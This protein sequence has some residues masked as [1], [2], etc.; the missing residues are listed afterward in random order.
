MSI[1][2]TD[3]LYQHQLIVSRVFDEGEEERELENSDVIDTEMTFLIDE[4]MKFKH[5][6]IKEDNDVYQV[7]SWIGQDSKGNARNYEFRVLKEDATDNYAKTFLDAIVGCVFERKC[8]ASRDQATIDDIEMLTKQLAQVEIKSEPPT[9]SIKAKLSP[10][11]PNCVET[12]K[13]KAGLNLYDTDKSIHVFKSNVDV[14]LMKESGPH[15]V[16]WLTAEDVDKGNSGPILCLKL[17]LD[18]NPRFTNTLKSFMFIE[19][20]DGRF[21]SWMLKFNDVKSDVEF[22]TVFAKCFYEVANQRPYAKVKEDERV[23]IDRSYNLDYDSDEIVLSEEEEEAKQEEPKRTPSQ[24]I[25]NSIKENLSDSNNHNKN[26]SIGYKHDRSFISRGSNI[27]VFKHGN[28][29]EL[30]YCATITDIKDSKGKLTSPS[31][32]MLHNQDSSLLLMLPNDKSTLYDLDL[33]SGTIKQKI[34]VHDKIKCDDIFS[35][36]KYAQ[37]TS[38]QTLY[39]LNPNSMYRI[40]PRIGGKS[41]I[42]PTELKRYATKVQ[43]ICAATTPTGEIAVA[44][45]NGEILL[46]NQI[47]KNA[48][49]ALPPNGDK[50]YGLDITNDGQYIIATCKTYLL[51]VDCRIY[52]DV[53]KRTGFQKSFPKDEKPALKRLQLKPEHVAQISQ[54][55]NFTPAKFNAGQDI[56]EKYIVTSTGNY[57]VLWNFRQVKIGKTFAYSLKQYEE[58]IVGDNFRFNQDR[59]IVVAMPNDL[60][61]ASQGEFRT[62]ANLF[63]KGKKSKSSVVNSPS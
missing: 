34:Q 7:F 51:L 27:G 59:T 46:Y 38:E 15:Y 6:K 60:T 14:R 47:G 19:K 50:I 32:M 58:S 49:T 35:T 31:K 56:L 4:N 43:F 63:Q 5:Q 16:Y 57:V 24:K 39:G 29:N 40:D 3:Y 54:D 8:N 62:P 18:L 36:S 48:K 55:I 61:M 1:Q 25:K 2:K 53:Q 44:S 10:L 20:R 42:V 11:P 22:K 12:L 45:E 26:L 23:Y 21:N 9:Q 52:S 17:G 13:I 41:S 33:E 28:G 37:M 30:E